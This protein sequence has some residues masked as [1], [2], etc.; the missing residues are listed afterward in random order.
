MVRWTNYRL[1]EISV[2]SINTPWWTQSSPSFLC[3]S[4]S[5]HSRL[6]TE[7]EPRTLASSRS[8]IQFHLPDNKLN[9]KINSKTTA[10]LVLAA[11][12]HFALGNDVFATFIT[13]DAT[14]SDSFDVSNPGC[15]EAEDAVYVEFSQG[16]FAGSF[17]GPYCL[18]AFHVA[19]CKGAVRFQQCRDDTLNGGLQDSYPLDD[20]LINASSYRWSDVGCPP[21]KRAPSSPTSGT[22]Q[23]PEDAF[24]ATEFTVAPTMNV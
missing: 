10:L 15:F 16:S 17:T 19:G 23:L 9:M 14:W 7:A 22:S 6:E 8:S 12:G 3:Q 4:I 21:T 1:P 2:S 18:Y 11:C 5:L 24:S 20:G 13:S